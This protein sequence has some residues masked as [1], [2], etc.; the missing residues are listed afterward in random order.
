MIL[1]F[2]EAL[3][4]RESSMWLYRSIIIFL[5][6]LGPSLRAQETTFSKDQASFWFSGESL[7]GKKNKHDSELLDK[8]KQKVKQTVLSSLNLKR[9][10]AKDYSLLFSTS[11]R[12]TEP[13]KKNVS[14]IGGGPAGLMTAIYAYIHGI[15]RIN[16]VERR[17]EYTRERVFTIWKKTRAGLEEVFGKKIFY[18]F[19][20][21]FVPLSRDSQER[22]FQ[23][24][25]LLQIKQMEFFLAIV[26]EVLAE[27]FPDILKTFYGYQ[28]E[29]EKNKKNTD[30][31]GPKHILIDPAW[32][33]TRPSVI[34]PT[35]ILVGADAKDSQVKK[36]ANIKT[37][38]VSEKAPT[39]V[40]IFDNHT[41]SCF[42]VGDIYYS[43]HL[44]S[45]VFSTAAL[46]YM[47]SYSTKEESFI[48][49]AKTVVELE[50]EVMNELGNAETVLG[51]PHLQQKV[52]VELSL[53]EKMYS[54]I[55]GIDV[56]LIGDA[57]GTVHFFTG[58]GVNLAMEQARNLGEFF[59]EMQEDDQR[60]KNMMR[61]GM[62]Y[63][64]KTLK[65]IREMQKNGDIYFEK[66]KNKNSI[67]KYL[68]D[69]DSNLSFL[70]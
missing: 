3:S 67:H 53:A 45:I 37:L 69:D 23:Y 64:L 27:E 52:D 56:F 5:L 15:H 8:I 51:K 20:Q 19:P 26:V 49:I 48:P 10:E 47:A 55:N 57:A 33:K 1:E 21:I 38:I 4:F 14:I 46:V 66:R 7:P 35:D 41:K 58:S 9:Q 54:Q 63:H 50:K 24:T 39:G 18:D 11:S 61:I 28:F 13:A 43:S 2:V 30:L 12:S 70:Y 17:T 59:Q 65:S 60:E 44:E 16:L 22:F 34:I 25:W 62:Q 6:I 36:Y 31:I 40:A 32:D 42:G 29:A 68:I